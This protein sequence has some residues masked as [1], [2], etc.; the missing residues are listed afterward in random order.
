MITCLAPLA[1]FAVQEVL[2]RLMSVENSP[3]GPGNEPG[4][5]GAIGAL[6]PWM[7]AAYVMVRAL[8]ALARAAAS[9]LAPAAAIVGPVATVQI[10]PPERLPPAG[11]YDPILDRPPRAPPR[12]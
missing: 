9:S 6:L 10:V 4:I 12:P 2:E 7:A 8:V 5:V 3:F 11:R 1:G